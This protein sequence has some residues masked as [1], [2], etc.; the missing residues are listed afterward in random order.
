MIP[1]A[2]AALV[3]GGA[4]ATTLGLTRPLIGW[5]RARQ[6]G[7]AIRADGPDHAAKA[8]TPTMGG[9]AL[10][11]AVGL[12]GL[13]IV[14]VLRPTPGPDDA[15]FGSTTTVFLTLAAMAGFGVLGLVDDLAGLARRR[16][17]EAGIGLTARRMIALQ[18]ALAVGVCA[19]FRA[20]TPKPDG[21]PWPVWLFPLGVV[22][23]VGTTNGVNFA[24]GLDGL[25][26]GL[27]AIA[28]GA[29][30]LTV[31]A[32]WAVRLG[33]GVGSMPAPASGLIASGD[34]WTA[35]PAAP[36]LALAIAAACLAFLVYNRHPAQ[37]FMGNVTSM[38]L[39]AGLATLAF[40]MGWW[41]L[42]PVIGAVF[43]VEVVSDIV[44]VAVFK[45]TG[46]RR[47]FR[48]APLHHHFELGG[49][50][51]TTVVRRFWLAGL[52]AGAAGL[53]LVLI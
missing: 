4:F 30:G 31:V 44:Q 33:P 3:V 49:W 9:L 45:A 26:A 25:A 39:G 24:D 16:G 50:P 7:K 18:T 8:G 23:I 21:S 52:A 36:V 20:A 48:M 51:E 22:A 2:T 42:L 41:L 27:A 6:L 34:P 12:S 10:L 5:L 29:L 35:L 53:A 11:A 32:A 38:A 47:V 46:G 37:V 43:V 19:A 14:V 1:V 40:G 13:A 17:G 15:T 28:Y